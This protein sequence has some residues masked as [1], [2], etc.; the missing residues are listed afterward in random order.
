MDICH[1]LVGDDVVFVM[2]NTVPPAIKH[3]MD[4][5]QGKI[6]QI[7]FKQYT[8]TNTNA[9]QR[10]KAIELIRQPHVLIREG[11]T[12]FEFPAKVS[13]YAHRGYYG[14]NAYNKSDLKR[15]FNHG[16]GIYFKLDGYDSSIGLLIM[17][18]LM[19]F[20]EIYKLRAMDDT[21]SECI[22]FNRDV[23]DEASLVPPL[24]NYLQ[25]Y[26]GDTLSC[27]ETLYKYYRASLRISKKQLN[28][29][30]NKLA[31]NKAEA[32]ALDLENFA[33][34]MKKEFHK[35]K[36]YLNLRTLLICIIMKHSF[37]SIQT[38]GH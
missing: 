22:S 30:A 29:T 3:D 10:K 20:I 16:E 15:H 37:D 2:P 28:K 12:Y 1:L 9:S 5:C 21:H 35:K 33:D 13:S 14:R 23:C 18:R 38:L 8:V 17:F 11:K 7:L 19:P 31:S 6:N 26:K 4:V 32:A 27:Y 36:N 24:L 34:T 25:R